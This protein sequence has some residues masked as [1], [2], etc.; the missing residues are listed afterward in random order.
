MIKRIFY[1]RYEHFRKRK[2]IWIMFFI[3]FLILIIALSVFALKVNKTKRENLS[4]IKMTTPTM[5]A[6]AATTKETTPTMTAT[7]ATT[8]ETTAST[9]TPT[10]TK[11][12]TITESRTST[13]ERATSTTEPTTSTTERV[14]TTTT[15]SITSTSTITTEVS[16]IEII[17]TSEFLKAK[18]VRKEIIKLTRRSGII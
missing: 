8:K 17:M 10:T 18:I 16:G 3:S 11:T 1:S 15:E 14:T 9:T 12:E 13:T 4:T 6:T 5:T 7:A 2:L